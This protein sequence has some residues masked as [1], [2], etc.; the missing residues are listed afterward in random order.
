MC[1][2]LYLLNPYLHFLSIFSPGNF[3]KI[4]FRIYRRYTYMTFQTVENRFPLLARSFARIKI[5]DSIFRQRNRICK[6]FPPQ[7]RAETRQNQIL[8]RF[9]ETF[10]FFFKELILE[11]QGETMKVLINLGNSSIF[12]IL[13]K[14]NK[15]INCF[16][17]NYVF[18]C[19]LFL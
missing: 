10:Q 13:T 15:N 7:F 2:R 12:E 5:F 16:T 8:P 6:V 1:I 11:R 9:E 3:E 18:A 14:N 4:K 19:S 17:I